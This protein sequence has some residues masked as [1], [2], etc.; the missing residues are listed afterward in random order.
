MNKTVTGSPILSTIPVRI[1]DSFQETSLDTRFICP[2]MLCRYT[3]RS[4][5]RRRIFLSSST[6]SYDY[7]RCR[8]RKFAAA[9]SACSFNM[10]QM[11]MGC[12]SYPVH[13]CDRK[14]PAYTNWRL[15]LLIVA[16]Y[17]K[18]K[19][20]GPKRYPYRVVHIFRQ[21]I[22]YRLRHK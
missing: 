20:K 16:H 18:G 3:C 19:L 15:L 17:Q 4:F 5:F 22:A 11:L 1:A 7:M 12:I 13:A 9:L 14:I 21:T 10:V 6:Y 8:W 2:I